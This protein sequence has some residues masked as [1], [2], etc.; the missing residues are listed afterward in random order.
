MYDSKIHASIYIY[1]F[2]RV[3]SSISTTEIL[4]IINGELQDTS[5]L[6]NVALYGNSNANIVS[7]SG[8]WTLSEN[9]L[10]PRFFLKVDRYTIFVIYSKETSY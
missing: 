3:P 4:V 2:G 8:I 5:E 9:Y 1:I 10:K 6:F 7:R